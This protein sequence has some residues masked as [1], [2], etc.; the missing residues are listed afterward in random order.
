MGFG[1][2]PAQAR[3][4]GHFRIAADLARLARQRIVELAVAIA[5]LNSHCNPF[6]PRG[7]KLI[8]PDAVRDEAHALSTLPTPCPAIWPIFWLGFSTGWPLASIGTQIDHILDEMVL[9]RQL[10]RAPG[11]SLRLISDEKIHDCS[12]TSSTLPDESCCS[13]GRPKTEN[14]RNRAD[15]PCA[16]PS[17]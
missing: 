17:G 10:D 4:R 16:R 3:R 5:L 12:G 1:N 9:A 7:S 2:V 11:P 8:V 14:R 13:D 6:G 15:R